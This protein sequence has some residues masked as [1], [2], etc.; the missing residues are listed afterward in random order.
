MWTSLH[1]PHEQM[2]NIIVPIEEKKYEN[3]FED[4]V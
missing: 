1:K 3:S 4:S 2:W